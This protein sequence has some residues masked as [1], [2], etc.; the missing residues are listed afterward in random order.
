[1]R[2]VLKRLR[3]PVPPL[4]AFVVF[5]AALLCVV[6]ALPAPPA[7]AQGGRSIIRDAEI[8]NI[9]R[10]FAVP[11]FQA[12]GLNPQNVRI[13]LIED[14]TLNA[15]VAGGQNIFVHTGL[16]FKAKGPDALIGVL[17]HETG[18]IEGGHLVR[19]RE[20]LEQAAIVQMIGTILGTA[21]A[22]AS[23]RSDVGQAVIMGSQGTGARAFLKYSRTQE[24]GAD[25]A[26]MRLLDAT[27]RSAKGLEEFLGTLEDQEILSQRFQD[28]YVQSHPV[29]AERISTLRA[30]NE[31]SPNA[32][33][34]YTPDERAAFDRMVA[35]IYGY[36]EP[37][38]K[39]LKRYPE[40]DK[41]FAARYARAI[42]HYRAPDL[43]R[44][45]VL[46]DELIDEHPQ[47]PY[48]HELKG[49]ML[50]EHG[51]I[52]DSLK[53]YGEAHKFAPREPLIALGLA[54]AE[55]ETNDPARLDDA[56]AHFRLTARLGEPSAFV[57]RQMGI[58]YGRKG[59]E[60][61]S[62]LALAEAE[63]R[64]GNLADAE[65][66]ATRASK[67]LEEG[68]GAHLQALDIIQLITVTR[69]QQTGN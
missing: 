24:S 4:D 12:A 44:A 26:A 51:R 34:R 54:R 17:A 8:E 41:S 56:I 60:G 52:E 48:L 67:K 30:H 35:K 62:A 2:N 22:V 7:W 57:W 47:D 46:I 31:T 13:R 20:A 66:L 25:Q 10:S 33:Q 63:L 28:P 38:G 39:V 69:A 1:M 50:F 42:A 21:A 68:T 43:E 59:D 18:H 49:Q 11:L 45:L 29:S 64:M 23:K 19:T 36:M 65:M 61:M 14:N 58:A 9:I 40:D 55:M 15:F 53:A 6:V 16:I 5:L 3:T 27:G 32:D 37:L